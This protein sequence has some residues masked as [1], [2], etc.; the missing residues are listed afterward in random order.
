MVKIVLCI[1]RK[2]K[3]ILTPSISFSIFKKGNKIKL[4]KPFHRNDFIHLDD[5]IEAVIK[6]IKLKKYVISDLDIDQV[7]LH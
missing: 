7:K 1:W 5:V 4:N 3:I 6:S 2:T